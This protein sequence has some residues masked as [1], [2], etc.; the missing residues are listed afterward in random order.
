VLIYMVW[1]AT[2][3]HCLIKWQLCFRV[4]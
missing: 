1:R 2:N 3:W 4:N